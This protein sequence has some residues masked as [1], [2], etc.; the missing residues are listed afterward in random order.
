ML[1]ACLAEDSIEKCM[2]RAKEIDT[3]MVEHRI[4]YLNDIHSLDKLYKEIAQPVI[5]TVRPHWEGGRYTESERSRL[6]VIKDAIDAECEAIDIELATPTDVRGEAVGYAKERGVLVIASR[7]VFSGTPDLLE[8]IETIDKM[9]D[10]GADV[11]KIVTTANETEDCNVIIELQRH[12]R[13]IKFPLVSFAMGEIGL[14]TRVS[15]I[16]ND[17]PFTYVSAGV[18]TA[19]GQVD[20][21]RMRVLMEGT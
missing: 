17:A 6:R 10:M 9:R 4:D 15:S 16:R 5:A 21:S 19:P 18:A 20:A 13:A 8:L 11:G 12:A 3:E 7:H 1:C 2:D 14:M